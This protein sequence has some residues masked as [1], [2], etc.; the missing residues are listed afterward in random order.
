MS[1]DK[2][3]NG[4]DTM[5]LKEAV[6]AFQQDASLAKFTFR[7][8]NEWLSGGHNRT[9]IKEFHGAGE[10]HRTDKSGFVVEAD[11]P[12]VLLGGDAAPNPVEHLLTA[13]VTCLTSSMVYHAA[14]RGIVIKQLEAS[15]EGDIDIQGFLGL[16]ES[17]RKG[18]QNISVKFKVKSDAPEEKLREC[19]SFSPV[20]DVVTNGTKVDVAIEKG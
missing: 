7:A 12:E 20:F 19:A 9:T 11:E 16:K 17:V 15:I 10:E 5:K 18:Y 6:G 2:I 8:T 4:V 13:L 1:N 3:V 14:A